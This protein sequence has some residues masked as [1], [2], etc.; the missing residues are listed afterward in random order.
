MPHILRVLLMPFAVMLVFCAICGMIVLI[1]PI[2][3]YQC[4]SNMIFWVLYVIVAFV[5]TIFVAIEK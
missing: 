4:T 5:A 1:S 3:W 2:T